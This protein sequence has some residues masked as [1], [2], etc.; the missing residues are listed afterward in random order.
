MGESY[1]V[2]PGEDIIAD[3]VRPAAY[4]KHR[5]QVA[6]VT[7]QRIWVLKRNLIGEPYTFE[8]H[9]IQEC[10]SI[11]YRKSYALGGMLGGAVMLL[12]GLAV[13]YYGIMGQLTGF[14]VIFQTGFLLGTGA[15]FVFGVRRH[16]LVFHLG[17]KTL[18]WKSGPGEFK[19]R[20]TPI[21]D[22]EAFAREKEITTTIPDK[23][24]QSKPQDL[25]YC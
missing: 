16:K 4:L 23:L 3:L 24:V 1:H 19:D 21:A 17:Q 25:P 14:G 10:A 7:D 11:S 15:A 12:A 20:I 13:L 9:A 5:G 2:Q 22:I 18:V 6:A 8:D